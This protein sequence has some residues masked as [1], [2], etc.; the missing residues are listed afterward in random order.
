MPGNCRPRSSRAACT[1]APVAVTSA[2]PPVCCRIG[3]GTLIL[4]AMTTP[5]PP[6]SVANHNL[7]EARRDHQP[8]QPGQHRA[9]NH[10]NVPSLELHCF[11]SQTCARGEQAPHPEC[12][13]RKGADQS[14]KDHETPRP[15]EDQE[16]EEP[17]SD[18]GWHPTQSCQQRQ[19][20]GELKGGGR[21][22][23]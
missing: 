7:P 10:V 15:E 8:Q 19:P 4:I 5:T 14:A 23:E 16:E 6:F 11:A 12:G 20:A 22:Q 9:K 3:V 21:E 13:D 17:R 18:A 1:V 2:L